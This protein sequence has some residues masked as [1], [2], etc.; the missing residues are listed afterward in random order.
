MALVSL[1]QLLDH[2]AEYGYGIPAFNV[3]NLEQV[4]AIMQA[5]QATCSPVILQASAGAR[6]Y[7]GEAYL[8]HLVLAAVESH[9]DIP[10]VLHQDHATSPAI[11]QQAIRSGFTSVMMDGSLMSDGKT[12]ASYD[13]N[14]QV[15]RQVCDLAHAIGVSV[16]G[17][18]GCLGSL[19]TGQAGEE[20]GIGAEGAL[21]HSQLLTDPAQAKEFVELTGVDALAIAIGTSHG[22]YKFTRKPSGDILDIARI[23]AIHAMIP[24]THLVMHGSSSVPQDWLDIIRE[25]GGEIKETYGVPV[26]EIQRGIAHGVRKV[27][28]DTDIRLA[29]T[30]AMRREMASARSEFDPRKALIAARKAAQ[31][32][33]EER[34][35]AFGCEGR[36]Q[37]IRVVPLEAMAQNYAV[38]T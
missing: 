20:D 4:Q 22:A 15:T 17:E 16:E 7:A 1:R 3:N 33:C 19:E 10:V 8:R 5:A 14:V 37:Q 12:P 9:P 32:L 11:C 2:A 6:K 30:G 21:D 18:L 38:T 31:A 24:N 25:F 28:I 36:A 27:N 13:Y 29:M 35:K 26:E 34:F 23:E